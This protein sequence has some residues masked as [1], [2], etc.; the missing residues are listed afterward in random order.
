MK[1]YLKNLFDKDLLIAIAIFL[2]TIYS[3]TLFVFFLLLFIVLVFVI[4][5]I[6]KHL[7][8]CKTKKEKIFYLISITLFLILFS[9]IMFF[10]NSLIYLYFFADLSKI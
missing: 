10:A 2:I 5:S 3:F 1:E 9:L 6:I 4:K 7:K 8:L